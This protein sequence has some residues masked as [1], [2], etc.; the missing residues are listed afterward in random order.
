MEESENP[1]FGVHD[2]GNGQADDLL[3][4]VVQFAGAIVRQVSAAPGEGDP[5]LCFRRLGFGIAE[6]GNEG[7]LIPAL[8]PGPYATPAAPAARVA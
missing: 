4:L 7:G 5:G 6:F 1:L 3:V 8:S 2:Y